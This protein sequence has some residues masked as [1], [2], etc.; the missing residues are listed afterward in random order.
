VIQEVLAHALVA[1]WRMARRAAAA[2]T[3][4]S[5]TELAWRTVALATWSQLGDVDGQLDNVRDVLHAAGHVTTVD[6]AH[7]V[8]QALDRERQRREDAVCEIAEAAG[9]PDPEDTA[10][11]DLAAVLAFVSRLRGER[12]GLTHPASP[13]VCQLES[14]AEALS[15]RE[16]F[17]SWP[18]STAVSDL[19]AAAIC[20]RHYGRDGDTYVCTQAPGHT[21]G[22]CVPPPTT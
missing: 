20:G 16:S 4:S 8:D 10:R 13:R 21:A 17:L 7:D 9:W 5:D 14:T 15:D 11:Y 12:D 6:L 2:P 1:G 3:P 22:G 19:H 18:E